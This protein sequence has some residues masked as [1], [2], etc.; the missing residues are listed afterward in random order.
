V[1]NA[2]GSK[3]ICDVVNGALQRSVTN[4]T[5]SAGEKQTHS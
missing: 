3:G 5:A 2:P 4:V 1:V